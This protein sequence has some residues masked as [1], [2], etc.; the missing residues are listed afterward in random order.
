LHHSLVLIRTLYRLS[1]CVRRGHRNSQ[2]CFV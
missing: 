2:I 1:Q